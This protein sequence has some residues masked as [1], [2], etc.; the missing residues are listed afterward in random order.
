MT[1][2]TLCGMTY[3]EGIPTSGRCTVCGQLFT[4]PDDALSEPR[5]ATWDFYK[6]F[7]LHQCTEQPYAV[8]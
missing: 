6:A 2:R 8:A 4:T 3:S 7:D 1:L 5:K